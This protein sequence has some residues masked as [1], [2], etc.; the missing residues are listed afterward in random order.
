MTTSKNLGKYIILYLPWGLAQLAVSVPEVSYLTAW[1]GS[2]FIFFLTLTGKIEPLPQ[3]RTFAE[4]LMR[5]IIMVQIIFAGFMC[6]T[7]IFYFLN[8][9]G[10][11]YFTKANFILATD[12]DALITAAQCQRYYC[13][14]H[15]AFVSGIIYFM[16]YP[17]KRKYYI[18]KEKLANLLLLTALI[19][20]PV[21]LLFARLPG[22]S[23]FYFQ[24]SSLSFI[25]GTLALAFALP[26][27]KVT[28]TLIC[29]ALYLFNFYQAM[30]SG[31][32]EPVIISVLVLGIFLYPNYKKT[33]TIIFVPALIILFMVLPAYVNSF[34]QNVWSG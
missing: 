27:Q 15:A 29:L 21:S 7:S 25:A 1:L 33:V 4:Q 18:E 14:G 6:C 24:F 11:N 5:P 16:K 20:F 2:F 22:L 23:Q 3:D 19:S 17:V 26:L 12:S 8:L 32:K 28:N 9:L 10:Y 30:I 13:L 31:F 34:R